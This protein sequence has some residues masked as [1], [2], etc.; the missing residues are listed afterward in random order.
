MKVKNKLY[1]IINKLEKISLKEIECISEF[2][3]DCEKS[4]IHEVEE[5]IF[6]KLEYIRDN[7]NKILLNIQKMI[8]S[9]PYLLEIR[10]NYD[11]SKSSLL[12]LINEK[13]QPGWDIDYNLK[14]KTSAREGAREWLEKL[15]SDLDTLDRQGKSFKFN[16]ENLTKKNGK[17][18][19]GN[20]I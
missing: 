3:S 9:S 2:L 6:S 11:K 18:Y 1:D 15:D 5:K 16:K 20:K 14:N 17:E 7:Y 19:K 4:N 12:E 8:S 13:D 10:E